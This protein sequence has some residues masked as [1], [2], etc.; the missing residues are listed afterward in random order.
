MNFR[1]RFRRTVVLRK[2]NALRMQNSVKSICIHRSLLTE[3]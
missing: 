3:L 2:K 1:G